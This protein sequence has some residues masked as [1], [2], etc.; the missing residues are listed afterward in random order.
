VEPTPTVEAA[1]SATAEATATR[2]AGC[3]DDDTLLAALPPM[4]G[5]YTYALPGTRAPV[6][7]GDWVVAFPVLL[8]HG[9]EPPAEVT[10]LPILL[11]QADGAWVWPNPLDSC[12]DGDLPDV[13]GAEVCSAYEAQA[14]TRTTAVDSAPVLGPTGLGALQLGMSREQ[15]QATGLVQPFRNEPNS[16]QCLWRSELTDAPVGTG[17]VLHSETLG[18]ATIDAYAGVHTP[19]GISIGSS[20]ADVKAAYPGFEAHGESGHTGVG[21]PG[22]DQ[23]GYRIAYADSKVVE[24][25]LQYSNQGCYE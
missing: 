5:G 25:T 20:L 13:I 23:A 24:L 1:P 8:F 15:A 19:E 3:P 11:E 16:D 4:D 6:C 9:G 10:Q 14:A 2:A 18:I 17:L 22:N 21:V 7:S 12:N